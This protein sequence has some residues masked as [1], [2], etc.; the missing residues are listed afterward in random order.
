MVAESSRDGELRI[1]HAEKF[2]NSQVSVQMACAGCTSTQIRS[3]IYVNLIKFA[4]A[5]SRCEWSAG[6][7]PEISQSICDWSADFQCQIAQANPSFTGSHD[8]RSNRAAAGI[9]DCQNFFKLSWSS[10]KFQLPQSLK[11]CSQ[12]MFRHI[13]LLRF[14]L[15]RCKILVHL[16][17]NSLLGKSR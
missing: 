12:S 8:L 3:Q 7:W 11:S 16:S 9:S 10:E 2:V 17:R 15:Q 5:A 13:A 1:C 6:I 4:W 14:H